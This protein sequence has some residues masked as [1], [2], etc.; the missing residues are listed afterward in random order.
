M[1]WTRDVSLEEEADG[2][3]SLIYMSALVPTLMCV[4]LVL[5]IL[6]VAGYYHYLC[7]RILHD[8]SSCG[9]QE[10]T[11][12]QQEQAQESAPESAQE[13]GQEPIESKNQPESLPKGEPKREVKKE[14]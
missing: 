2:P 10:K 11:E 13:Q 3:L 8:T 4:G 7:S 5:L 9:T 14:K 6:S 12:R 1:C